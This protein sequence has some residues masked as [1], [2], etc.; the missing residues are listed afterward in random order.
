MPFPFRRSVF[1]IADEEPLEAFPLDEPAAAVED[2]E[3]RAVR[4]VDEAAT[5]DSPQADG[6]PRPPLPF[7][8]SS[9]KR[10]AALAAA[11]AALGAGLGVGLHLLGGW[12]RPELSAPERAQLP[13]TVQPGD[14]AP[15]GGRSAERRSPREPR[16]RGEGE[17]FAGEGAGWPAARRARR[18]PA[19]VAGD[20][21]AATGT[22][23]QVAGGVA[24]VAPAG[25]PAPAVVPVRRVLGEEFGF[26]R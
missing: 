9:A 17:R 13:T 11:V 20:P 8:V 12:Q 3:P 15:D 2:P 10:R 1:E 19:P 5:G 16:A 23:T 26:E 18:S 21:V 22:P 25:P 4:V 24:P 14:R 6:S 7:F